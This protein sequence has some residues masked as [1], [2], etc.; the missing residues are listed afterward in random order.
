MTDMRA[1]WQNVYETRLP[2]KVSWYQSVPEPSLSLFE[3]LDKARSASVIDIGGGASTLV[4]HLLERQFADITILDL[5]AAALTH[6]KKR[7]GPRADVVTWL[8][9]DITSW[10]PARAYDVWHDRAV[11][12]FL[13]SHP[14]QD[15]Y[16][17]ALADGT[18]AGSAVIMATFAL[19]G[20]ERCSGL[21]VQRYDSESLAARLG[22]RFVLA[23]HDVDL[24]RTPGDAVQKFNF[25]VF[26]RK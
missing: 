8:E 25:A 10:R 21:P 2:T 23:A 1:H 24:H 12:H 26:K 6:A 13:V 7:I 9:A 18:R 4:D 5:S 11:F 15:A 16:L 17:T 20:P 14:A 3:S 22:P 19:D